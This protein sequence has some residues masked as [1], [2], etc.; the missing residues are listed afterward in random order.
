MLFRQA[1]NGEMLRPRGGRQP[2]AVGV[3]N[4][5][6]LLVVLVALLA[7]LVAADPGRDGGRLSG[8][9]TTAVP[10]SMTDKRIALQSKP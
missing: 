3:F 7:V 9:S 10:L 8:T 1:L 6:R 5:L 4:R 2:L